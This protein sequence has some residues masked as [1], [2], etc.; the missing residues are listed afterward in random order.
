MFQKIMKSITIFNF[1]Y[2][3]SG[4][5]FQAIKDFTFNIYFKGKLFNFILQLKFFSIQ[6][7]TSNQVHNYQ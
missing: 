3:D 4:D 5:R 2:F 1:H 6:K 7:Y